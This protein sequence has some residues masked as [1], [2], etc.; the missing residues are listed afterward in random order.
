MGQSTADSLL[1]WFWPI[2]CLRYDTQE[3]LVTLPMRIHLF[4]YEWDTV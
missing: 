3:S 2:F 4:F 1:C